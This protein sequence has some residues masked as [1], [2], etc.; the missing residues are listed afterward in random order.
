MAYFV[1]GAT[2]FIGRYLVARLVKRNGPIYALVRKRSLARLDELREAWG[3]DNKRVIAVVG[4]LAK[5]KLGIPAA[6]IRKLKGRIDH[7]F[8]LAAIY[9]LQA[10]ADDQRAAN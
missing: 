7:F 3:V 6:D 8:H 5:P 2:G 1:T 10:S 9:D 4:D